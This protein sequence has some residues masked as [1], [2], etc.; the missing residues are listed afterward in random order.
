MGSSNNE[1]E[2]GDPINEDV[3]SDVDVV[4]VNLA[5]VGLMSMLWWSIWHMSVQCQCCGGRFGKCRFDVDV[6]VVELA[7]VGLMSMLWWSIW[8]MSVAQP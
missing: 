5:D 6:V 2:D 8:R 1:A 4:V 7:D 3:G